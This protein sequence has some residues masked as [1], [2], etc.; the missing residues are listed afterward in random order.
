MEKKGKY[1][2]NGVSFS[3]FSDLLFLPLLFH[4][5]TSSFLSG[6]AGIFIWPQNKSVE[7]LEEIA[8]CGKEVESFVVQQKRDTNNYLLEVKLTFK[9]AL[10]DIQSAS[11]TQRLSAWL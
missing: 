8:T 7:R 4:V 5:D 10:S 2:R 9:G 11:M 6:T 1:V 3:S